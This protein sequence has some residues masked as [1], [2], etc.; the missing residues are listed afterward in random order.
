MTGEPLSAS[1]ATRAL[2]DAAGGITALAMA[3]FTVFVVRY[4]PPAAQAAV[5]LWLALYAL[6]PHFFFQ[7]LVWGLPFF[8][9][10]GRLRLAAAVQAV[11]LLPTVLFYRAPWESEAVA[12]PYGVAMLALWALFAAGLVRVARDRR[13]GAP[14]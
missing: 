10:S 8:L 5:L 1:G 13:A 6:S 9:L 3:L 2:V 14:A 11:A 7:Y 12:V 4:R